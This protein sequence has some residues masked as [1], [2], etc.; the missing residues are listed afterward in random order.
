MSKKYEFTGKEINHF[1][2]ILKQIRR[3]SDGLVGGYIQSEN[4]LS[5][6]GDCF[7]YDNAKVF[8]KAKV[9]GNAQVYGN[10]L[11]SGN[12]WV[13]GNA[14]ATG[15]VQSVTTYK[16]NITVT[17][18]HIIIGCQCHTIEHWKANIDRI[19]KDNGYSKQEVKAVKRVLNGLLSLRK[20][21]S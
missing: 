21:N 17:D 15:L 14:T 16:N 11:V 7:V 1:G 10:A 2:R 4:N 5:H 9:S 13:N 3:L 18:N 12:A 19:G 6:N 20:E 8:G